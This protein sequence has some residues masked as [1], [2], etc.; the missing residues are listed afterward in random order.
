VI[1]ALGGTLTTVSGWNILAHYI[2][3]YFFA[4]I[5]GGTIY[6]LLL[7]ITNRRWGLMLVLSLAGLIIYP[8]MMYTYSV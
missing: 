1:L 8:S 5:S 3:V 4:G 2:G 6:G 7:P